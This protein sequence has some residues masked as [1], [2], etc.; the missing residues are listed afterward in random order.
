MIW[1]EFSS[2]MQMAGKSPKAHTKMSI[3]SR[4]KLLVE[5]FGAHCSRGTLARHGRMDGVFRRNGL[6]RRPAVCLPF[7]GSSSVRCYGLS[8]YNATFWKYCA[9]QKQGEKF[10]FVMWLGVFVN[11]LTCRTYEASFFVSENPGKEISGCGGYRDVFV[12]VCPIRLRRAR[13]H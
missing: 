4:K 6:G 2:R 3:S 13:G 9:I 1:D 12:C 5:M 11:K 10:I 8:R 7:F